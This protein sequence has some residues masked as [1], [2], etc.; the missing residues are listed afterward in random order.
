MY[1]G[2]SCPSILFHL[3]W[4]VHGSTFYSKI[5]TIT[6]SSAK[7]AH[8]VVSNYRVNV[9][10]RSLLQHLEVVTDDLAIR[11]ELNF[12]LGLP[13]L[14]LLSRFAWENHSFVH[15]DLT[16]LRT[17]TLF[18]YSILLYPHSN[19]PLSV[20][21]LKKIKLQLFV[22]DK[23]HVKWSDLSFLFWVVLRLVIIDVKV[24]QHVL[25][26]LTGC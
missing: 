19:L 1:I 17:K 14:L 2:T 22:I 7:C 11:I 3:N 20:N 4:T 21:N 26:M 8:F 5:F 13:L 24:T 18:N 6:G 10:V 9:V 25:I 15:F 16:H 23:R 12:I